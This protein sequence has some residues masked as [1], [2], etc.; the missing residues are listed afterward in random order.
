MKKIVIDTL[1][2]D[3]SLQEI[4]EGVVLCLE[5]GEQYTPVLVGPKKEIDDFFNARN[6]SVEVIDA[7]TEVTNTTNPMTMLYEQ[8]NTALVKSYRYLKENEDAKGLITCSATGC[9]LVG[10]IFHLGLQE[11]LKFPVL[12]AILKHGD[13][14]EFLLA[15]CGANIDVKDADLDKFARLGSE[16]IGSYL[17][18]DSPRVGI[19]SNGKEEGKGNA[20]IKSA[21]KILKEDETINFIGNIEASDC[22]NDMAD[23]L[24]CDGMIG[25]VVLKVAES[26]ANTVAHYGDCKEINEKVGDR[27]DYNNNGGSVL[28][29]TKKP[30]VKA[31][32]AANRKTIAACYGQIVKLLNGGF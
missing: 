21:Q 10:S 19:I 12:G 24:V 5:K 17:N 18:I 14:N 9:V 7:E 11:G 23:V 15:D 27:F 28:I 25:N 1:G 2:G 4:L 8:D 6:I 26:V 13:G 3:L 30:V 22:F 31:H 32:G 20:Q 29:G 16:F